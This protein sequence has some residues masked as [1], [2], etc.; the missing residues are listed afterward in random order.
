MSNCQKLSSQ[1]KCDRLFTG[2]NIAADF[3]HPA[4][5][6]SRDRE[7]KTNQG[8]LMLIRVLIKRHVKKG[9]VEK[10]IEILK[11]LRKM[12]LNQQGYISGETLI[13]HYDSQSIMIVST[14]EKLDDWIRWEGSEERGAEEAKIEGLLEVTTKYE[15]YDIGSLPK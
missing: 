10:A 14:W 15:V 6:P 1:K 4:V 11:D 13:N 7:Y 2:G 12:A 3:Y 5:W 8:G 9:R